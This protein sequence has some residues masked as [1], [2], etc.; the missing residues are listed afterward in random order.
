MPNAKLRGQSEG[1]DAKMAPTEPKGKKNEKCSTNNEKKQTRTRGCY[2]Y[3][4][5]TSTTQRRTKGRLKINNNSI[6][7]KKSPS[8][9]KGWPVSK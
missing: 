1:A 4:R 2:R 3:S 5:Y 9:L 7:V 6:E 8:S